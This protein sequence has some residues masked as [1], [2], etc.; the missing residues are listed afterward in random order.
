MNRLL[1]SLC[2]ACSPAFAATV[3]LIPTQT[4]N[5]P[6]LCGSTCSWLVNTNVV[7]TGTS[8]PTFVN[9]FEQIDPQTLRYV[10]PAC[11]VPTHCQLSSDG[12][13]PV[14]PILSTLGP[15]TYFAILF[16]G[17]GVPLPP[18]LCQASNCQTPGN[19]I[20]QS[21]TVTVTN[22]NNV[23]VVPPPS[24][25]SA[26]SITYGGTLTNGNDVWSILT[27]PRGEVTLNGQSAAGV[28][29]SQVACTVTGITFTNQ[30]NGV[31]Q[32]WTGSG[33]QNC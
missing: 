22:V 30:D 31:V 33:W 21:A 17:N 11:A 2:L 5:P 24:G 1:L 6:A 14:I 9:I 4:T 15:H 28:W 26:A 29:G 10:S 18:S 23:V 19:I 13:W 27:A 12:T 20:A 7:I 16:D 3:T 32:C 8:P 25:C